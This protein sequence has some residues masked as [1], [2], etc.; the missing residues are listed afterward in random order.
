MMF[1]LGLSVA[2]VGIGWVS[3]QQRTRP[4]TLTAEDY[5]DIQQ[6][7]SNYVRACDMGGGGDGSDYVANF[8]D[9]GEFGGS[10]GRVNKGP[11]ALKRMIK[12]FHDGLKKNGWS[13]RHTYSG[14]LI[15]PTAEGAKGSVYALI[16][17]V[18]AKP[19]FV[20]H[21]GVYEDWLVKTPNGWK[22]KKRIF[23]PS[24]DFQPAMP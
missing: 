17:N 3:A 14:L 16:F 1:A 12:G 6:L 7:Y 11:E 19:P 20:D 4:P 23:K 8:T 21:S 24:G 5:M 2:V 10:G 22:F 9:D 13:S 18:T 15:T